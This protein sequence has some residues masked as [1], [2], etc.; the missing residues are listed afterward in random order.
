MK[1]SIVEFN[2][3]ENTISSITLGTFLIAFLAI[4][5]SAQPVCVLAQNLIA[6]TASSNLVKYCQYINHLHD[7]NAVAT[8]VS[9]QAVSTGLARTF[10]CIYLHTFLAVSKSNQ[11][12]DQLKSVSV[13]P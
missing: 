4:A 10:V 8:S 2:G 3:S 7:M 12:S 5:A 11:A 1:A 9:N 6:S 13:E